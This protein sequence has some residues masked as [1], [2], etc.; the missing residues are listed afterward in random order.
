MGPG[1][2]SRAPCRVFPWGA[3]SYSRAGAEFADSTPGRCEKAFGLPALP[4]QSSGPAGRPEAAAPQGREGTFCA[5]RGGPGGC[6]EEGTQRG[7]AGPAPA[8]AP[9]GSAE[10]AE[11]PATLRSGLSAPGRPRGRQAEQTRDA[12]DTARRRGRDS[13][14]LTPAAGRVGPRGQAAGCGGPGQAPSRRRRSVS[15]QVRERPGQR[16]G[17]VP[18]LR[19]RAAPG[20]V[21]G[22]G[23]QSR[24]RLG[25][26]VGFERGARLTPRLWA[27]RCGVP[28][29]RSSLSLRFF[30][31]ESPPGGRALPFGA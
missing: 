23:R 24:P 2:S 7:G 10:A 25:A 4:S 29:V 13:G 17:A 27:G 28:R 20:A 15:P 5:R 18:W 22:A 14:A 21:V 1:V 12:A 8:A 11:P 26:A 19:Q 30:R 9:E 16:R 6:L 3:E 31:R